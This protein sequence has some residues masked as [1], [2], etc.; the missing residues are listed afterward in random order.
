MSSPN[1]QQ[2]NYQDNVIDDSFPNQW[3]KELYKEFPF[4]N[5][6]RYTPN[7]SYDVLVELKS[8]I[9]SL[10]DKQKEEIIKVIDKETHEHSY[11]KQGYYEDIK[12]LI[13]KL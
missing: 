3:E 8:F 11:D 13:N 12:S 2:D 4:L 1:P 9:Q 5:E 7:G 6:T 10:L